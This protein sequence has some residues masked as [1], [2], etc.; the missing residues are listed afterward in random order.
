[1]IRANL[2]IKLIKIQNFVYYF[3]LVDSRNLSSFGFKDPPVDS[4][5]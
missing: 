5:I 1:M 4:R 2:V 3:S